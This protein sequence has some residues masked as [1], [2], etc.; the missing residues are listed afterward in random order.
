YGKAA[1]QGHAE[2][3]YRLGM[4]Y[5]NGEGVPQDQEKATKLFEKAAAQGNVGAKSELKQ[6]QRRSVL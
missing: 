3:Q 4:M 2:A 5:K 6:Q 1:A